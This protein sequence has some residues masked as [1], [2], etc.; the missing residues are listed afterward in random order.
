[1]PVPGDA[2]PH[3]P[4]LPEQMT[5]LGGLLH[6]VP[7][8]DKAVIQPVQPEFTQWLAE[9]RVPTVSVSRMPDSEASSDRYAV[10]FRT[11]QIGRYTMQI[12]YPEYFSNTWFWGPPRPRM[13]IRA[14]LE[15]V[16]RL[17]AESA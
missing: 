5:P 16:A 13:D 7:D 8:W 10:V 12:A 1:V 15:L 17:V 14:A 4:L 2:S 3:R 9:E 6:P 11:D